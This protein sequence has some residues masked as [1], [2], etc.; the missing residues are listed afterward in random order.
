[1]STPIGKSVWR[2]LDLEQVSASCVS[3]TSWMGLCNRI[4]GEQL[5]LKAVGIETGSLAKPLLSDH[6]GAVKRSEHT[7]PCTR[8][9]APFRS[10]WMLCFATSGARN[11]FQVRNLV[12]I[13]R[14]FFAGRIG[15]RSAAAELKWRS[16]PI[17]SVTL[18]CIYDLS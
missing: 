8:E 11:R 16:G 10:Q 15:Y 1:M 7:T 17:N 2:T 3:S 12:C 4:C 13:C 5:A 18:R 14:R 9:R 6:L